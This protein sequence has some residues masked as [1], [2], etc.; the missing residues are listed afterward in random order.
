MYQRPSGSRVSLLL[1]LRLM[2]LAN[3]TVVPTRARPA[4]RDDCA[5]MGCSA[6]SSSNFHHKDLPGEAGFPGCSHAISMHSLKFD[7]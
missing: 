7:D 2:G 6:L 3:L 5:G 1:T 4:G